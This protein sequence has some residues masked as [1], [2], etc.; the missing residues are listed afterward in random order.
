M[1]KKAWFF[2]TTSSPAIVHRMHK[3]RDPKSPRIPGSNPSS[4]F[5]S[6]VIRGK[7]PWPRLPLGDQQYRPPGML[8][9][10]KLSVPGVPAPRSRRTSFGCLSAS[11]STMHRSIAFTSGD[12]FKS[13]LMSYFLAYLLSHG[14]FKGTGEDK[15]TSDRE[16]YSHPSVYLDSTFPHLLPA[17]SLPLQC[18]QWTISH[19][20]LL[21]TGNCTMFTHF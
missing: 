19:F 18:A 17:S 12:F 4:H 14:K 1:E 2:L 7:L 8:W 10:L 20:Q 21:E 3:D 13:P 9:G 15:H 11:C 6:C 5:S 16:H